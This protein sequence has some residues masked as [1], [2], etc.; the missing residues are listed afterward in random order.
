MTY[1]AGDIPVGLGCFRGRVTGV[2]GA[3]SLRRYDRKVQL[4]P[5]ALGAYIWK[6]AT[7]R[8]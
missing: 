1:L 3:R 2:D 8:Y 7:H 5:A 4:D 6:R